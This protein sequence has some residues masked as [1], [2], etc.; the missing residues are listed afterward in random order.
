MGCCRVILFLVLIIF[1]VEGQIQLCQNT[2]NLAC[3]CETLAGLIDISSLGKKDG[4]QYKSMEATVYPSSY[5]FS[6]NPCY[7]FN[8][9]KCTSAASCQEGDTDSFNLGTQASAKWSMCDEDPNKNC[10]S[11]T[12]KQDNV[13]R[14]TIV[15]LTCNPSGETTFS[16][17]GEFPGSNPPQ[18]I[19]RLTSKCACPN[20]CGG[21]GGSGSGG[22]STGSIL[23]I[24][25]SVLVVVYLAGGIAFNFTRRGASGKE[26]IPN[27]ELWMDFPA[28]VKDGTV[29]F[30]NLFRRGGGG[31]S[32]ME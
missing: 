12:A 13:D 9:L 3:K 25:F 32:T 21:G 16:V 10:I 20:G 15:V 17:D 4:I 22:L 5:K 1:G 29:F 24:T 31:Y 28:L 26:A 23:C 8:D 2:D 27:V 14:T 7:P 11:Y 19:Y 30:I 18:Y 6:Y